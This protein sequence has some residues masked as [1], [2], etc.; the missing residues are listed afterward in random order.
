MTGIADNLNFLRSRIPPSV[1][2]VAVSKTKSVEEILQAYDAGQ[3][4]FGENRVQELLRKKDLLPPDIQWHMI[5]HLQSNKVKQIASFISMIHSVDS[6]KLLNIINAEANKAAR[7][8]DCLIEIFIAE[9]ET[10]SGFA[11]DEVESAL[12]TGEFKQFENVRICGLMGMA[13][14]T[15]DTGRV[16]REFRSLQELFKKLKTKH[17]SNNPEFSELSMGMSGDYEAAIAEGST[18]IRIG[19]LIFGERNKP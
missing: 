12:A 15:N 6:M 4:I 10:K 1:R 16:G 17:F 13:T 8:I 14:F 2:I 3:R 9:E 7:I 11:P 18:M 19:S 5:G